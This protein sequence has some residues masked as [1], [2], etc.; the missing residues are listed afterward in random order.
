MKEKGT[1]QLY[2]GNGKGKTTASLGLAFRAMGAGYSTIIIQFMK[3]QHYS[4]LNSALKSEGLIKIEQYG[5]ENF[6]TPDGENFHEHYNLG[7]EGYERAKHV[8]EKNL[9]D[10]IILD[11]IITSIFFKLITTEEII[12]L[13]KL[14]HENT[15]LILTGRYAPEELHKHCDL[16]TEMKEIKHYYNSG[17]EARVGIEN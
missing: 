8:L 6:C 13:I 15:E 17:I 7:R 16:I 11:E 1:V 9:F 2:T 14:K 3:G 5:S 12:K 4:E 10:I